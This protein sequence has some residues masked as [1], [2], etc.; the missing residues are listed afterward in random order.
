MKLDLNA[1]WDQAVRLIGMNRE[2]ML[3]LSGVFFF[4]PYV[5]FTLLVPMPD[6]QAAAGPAVADTSL[7]AAEL[8]GFIR[9]YW[10]AI[11]LA[12]A[13]Q[14]AGALAVMAVLGDPRRPTVQ[15][16]IARG[17][18][19]LP[20]SL[21]ASALATCAAIA[22]VFFAILIG[23]LTGSE[24]LTKTLALCAGPLALWLWTSLSLSS[25]AIAIEKIANPLAALRRSWRLTDGSRL[26]LAVFYV[27][28]LVAFVVMFQVIGLA[29][30]VLTALL[31]AESAIVVS[32][33]L[34]GIVQATFS[35]LFFAV[36][37]SVH[38]LLARAERALE[39]D[40]GAPGPA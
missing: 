26:R 17:S 12:S 11:L 6:I 14:T 13:V 3:I 32:T 23:A 4:L 34:L 39:S 33:L 7:L 35:L 18:A 22:A 37:A 31:S 21:L 29:V 10:W 40:S 20:S 5:M 25:P 9:Q 27:L 38:R 19:L 28:L 1:A 2:V 30:S 36:Q 8:N 24:V 15:A 16:A